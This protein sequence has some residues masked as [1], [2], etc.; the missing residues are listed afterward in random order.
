MVALYQAHKGGQSLNNSILL[1]SIIF[2]AL[3][4]LDW[5]FG[6]ISCKVCS[7]VERCWVIASYNSGQPKLRN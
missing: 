6:L 5:F 2:G 7:V 3:E 1:D 4:E